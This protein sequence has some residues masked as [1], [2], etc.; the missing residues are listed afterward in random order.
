MR[1]EDVNVESDLEI[2][3]NG[4][5]DFVIT[6]TEELINI[7]NEIRKNAG[8]TDLVERNS[9]N[10]VYYTYYLLLNPSE[11][12]IALK[13]EVSHGEKD[14][15]ALYSIKLSPEEEKLLLWKVTNVL[16]KELVKD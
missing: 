16:L 2:G 6:A 8:C 11:R 4:E 1:F 9:E 3:Y 7:T 15:Y 13:A 14:D 12:K 10:D 5:A